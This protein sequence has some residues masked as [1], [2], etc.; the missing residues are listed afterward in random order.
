M[1]MMQH[2]RRWGLVFATLC[3]GVVPTFGDVEPN[4]NIETA[5]PMELN[6]PYSGSLSDGPIV[7]NDD[8]YAVQVPEDGTL[9]VDYTRT[10]DDLKVHVRIYRSTGGLVITSTLLQEEGSVTANCLAAD[11][12]YVSVQ[13]YSANGDYTIVATNGAYDVPNDQEPNNSREQAFEVFGEGEDIQGH[14]GHTGQFS[15][16]FGTDDNDYYL[17]ETDKDGDITASIESTGNL[18]T[19]LVIQRV[20]G[21]NLAQSTLI[22][23]SGSVTATCRQ[24]GTYI[25]RVQRYSGCGSYTVNFEVSE[26]AFANDAEPNN[27]IGEIQTH[28]EEFQT[29]TGHLGHQSETGTND[30]DDYYYIISPRDGDV[31]VTMNLDSAATA[32]LRIYNKNGSSISTATW[33]TGEL[34]STAFCVA[35]DTIVVHVD[36]YG[37]CGSYELSFETTPPTYANDVEPNNTLGEINTAVEE[38]EEVTGHIGYEDVDTGTDHYDYFYILSP[39]DGDV[40]VT[41]NLDSAARSSLLILYKNGSSKSTA[42]LG[43]GELSTTAFCM[44]QDTLVVRIDRYSGCGS[45]EWSFE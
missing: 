30:D 14:L 22:D 27:S 34:S 37:G 38:F 23:A 6:T 32:Y 11:L 45:Y 24:Q 15:E 31:T 33:G 17:I 4:D 19:Y 1:K 42:V 36:R 18:R 2:L 8:F 40:T 25:L 21:P 10:A 41:M 5:E 28:V 29:V 44:A 3:I 7:D 13:R 26:L 39:R 12:Y 16:F 35:Q 43:T 20:D 9:T